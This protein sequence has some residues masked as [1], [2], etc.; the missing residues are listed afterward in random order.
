MFHLL[1][2]HSDDF[3]EQNKLQLINFFKQMVLEIGILQVCECR[4]LA[5]SRVLCHS[6]IGNTKPA[7]PQEIF[8][9]VITTIYLKIIHLKSKPHLSGVNQLTHKHL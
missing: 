7:I 8:M 6:P 9:K 3:N 2:S 1:G 4:V 5:Q